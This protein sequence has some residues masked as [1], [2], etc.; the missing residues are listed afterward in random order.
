MVHYKGGKSQ[1]MKTGA[2]GGGGKEKKKM[3]LMKYARNES[4]FSKMLPK[5][6]KKNI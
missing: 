6:T 4:T 2:R 1:I 5:I 3:M